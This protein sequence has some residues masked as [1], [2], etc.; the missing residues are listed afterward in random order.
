MSLTTRSVAADR[1][2]RSIPEASN[3]RERFLKMI[4]RPR[5]AFN[6][7]E[8]SLLAEDG[9]IETRFAFNSEAG[10][11]VP[12][13]MVA[14][15][16]GAER[17]P[18]VI[19]L[20]GTGGS[21]QAMLPLLREFAQ[22][23]VVGV[24]IDGRFAGERAVG[25][26]GSDAYRAAILSTWKTGQGFPFYYDTVW[27]LL[28][29]MD[30]LESRDDVDPLHFGAIGFSKGG[31]ELYRAAAVD[32]RLYASVPCIGVQSFGWALENDA[33]QSRIG[34]IQ[35]AVDAAAIEAGVPVDA[36]F[37]RKF[38]DRVAPGIYKQFDG[39]AMLPLIAPRSLLVINGDK[40]DRTPRAGLEL[41]IKPTREA[42]QRAN[43]AK[44]FEFILQPNTQHQV[45]PE[46]Q[47]KAIEWLVKHLSQVKAK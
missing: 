31:T 25:T 3:M 4:D 12:G 2:A 43:A 33:W 28:R 36:A 38:Y 27:D 46:S 19:V 15:Q 1:P 9:L 5:V 11:R 42:Y 8:K 47:D 26:S 45:R 22:R 10:Q 32:D 21:K 6:A 24:A 40:D 23:G 20:H 39:P 37:I 35:S 13:I 41:C 29:L 16:N 18:V 44:H 30:Y 14:S 7:V 17:R 34:T